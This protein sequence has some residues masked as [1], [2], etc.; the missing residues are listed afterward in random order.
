VETWPEEFYA[1]LV[2]D[3]PSPLLVLDLAG[4]AVFANPD[5]L[6]LL[7]VADVDELV[8]TDLVPP[9]W[10]ARL[11]S[12]LSSVAEGEPERSVYLRPCPVTWSGVDRWVDM[13]CRALGAV[14]G[15]R[16]VVLAFR[17]VSEFEELRVAIER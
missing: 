7:G 12:F 11:R 10:A 5:A 17:D 15:F 14:A 16:G 9:D 1:A 3:M 2:R 8:A 4:R 6:R 13:T